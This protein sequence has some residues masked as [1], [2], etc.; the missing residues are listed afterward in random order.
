MRTYIIR[1]VALLVPVVWGAVT[2]LFVL[3]YVVPGDPVEVIAG[4]SSGRAIPE[5]V[6]AN[7]EAK[8]GLDQ[9]ILTQY[10]DYWGRLL[11]GDL[12]E[13]YDSGRSVNDILRQTGTNSLRLTIWAI[14]VEVVIGISAGILSALRRYS[15]LDAV[16]TVSTA[17]ASAIPVFV[18]GYLLQNMLGVLP[19]QHD[20]PSWAR[21]P[22][23][24]IGENEW[25]LFF[26]PAGGQWRNLLLPAVTLACVSTALVARMTRTTM[27][28]VSRAD[29]MRTARAKGLTERQVTLKHGLRNALIPVVTLIGLDVGTMI[30]SAILTETVFNWPGMGST[31]ARA[32]AARDAPVV[33]GLTT[34]LVVVYVVVNLLVDLSYGWLDPRIRF[35]RG[36]GT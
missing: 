16:T 10:V 12:G 24:G 2:L 23:Q 21:F 30:G 18:L 11:Q 35:G 8:Y 4:G 29:F 34:V 36:R 33:L 25:Y 20:W 3:F 32:L 28:E 19:N 5:N 14:L 9:P 15:F 27:L 17:A 1:R 22:V 31:I 6:R 26:I 13:S 7:I